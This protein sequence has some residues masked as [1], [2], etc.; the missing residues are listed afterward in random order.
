MAVP[1]PFHSD[2]SEAKATQAML[3][4]LDAGLDRVR[5]IFN[6]VAKD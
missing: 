6:L 1:H 4:W 2:Y 3:N 5:W